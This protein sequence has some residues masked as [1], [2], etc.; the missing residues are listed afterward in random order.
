MFTKDPLKNLCT[1]AVTEAARRHDITLEAMDVQPDHVHVVAHIPLTWSPSK[2]IKCLKG[3]SARLLFMMKPKLR[4]LYPEGNLWSP[5]KFIATVGD[6]D[7]EHI[8]DYVKNQE[9]HHAKAVPAR[10]AQAKLER[11]SNLRF[12]RNPRPER[13]EGSPEGRDFNPGRMSIV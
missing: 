7:I 3:V 8:V 12:G 5:G 4:L 11:P 2:A 13:S 6:V 9:A 1:I 10:N